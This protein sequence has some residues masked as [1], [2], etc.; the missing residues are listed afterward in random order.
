[1]DRLDLTTID[2]DG[3]LTLTA[4]RKAAEQFVRDRP[5]YHVKWITPGTT[6][7]S[8]VYVIQLGG[9]TR[10]RTVTL[11]T[12]DGNR[13]TVELSIAA[14]TYR[15]P[16]PLD[17]IATL[18]NRIAADYPAGSPTNALAEAPSAPCSTSGQSIAVTA[19]PAS[20]C[21]PSTTP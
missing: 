20:T 8:R 19:T 6:R 3:I 7:F 16:A 13:R 17:D 18:L 12:T 2:L 1:M 9:D 5:Q 21:A 14:A 10:A 4:G 11:A 15:S